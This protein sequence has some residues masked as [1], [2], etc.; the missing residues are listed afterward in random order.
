LTHGAKLTYALLLGYAWQ[1]GSCFP[2]QERL[3]EDL[4][5]E[6]KAVIRYLKELKDSGMVRVIRR[7][8]GQTNLYILPKLADVALLAKEPVS[9]PDV[10]QIGYQ[11]VPSLGQPVVLGS[12]HYVHPADKTQKR[13][14]SIR[15]DSCQAESMPVAKAPITL[16]A[17]QRMRLR[18]AIRGEEPCRDKPDS[19]PQDSQSPAGLTGHIAPGDSSPAGACDALVRPQAPNRSFRKSS[20][21]ATRR[22]VAPDVPP[23]EAEKAVAA[24]LEPLRRTFRDAASNRATITRAVHLLDCSGL[25]SAVF[26]RF[27]H[28]A[29]ARTRGSLQVGV[30]TSNPMAYFFACLVQLLDDTV[31]PD[32]PPEPGRPRRAG[33]PGGAPS[34]GAVA[35]SPDDHPLWARVREELAATIA[36]RSYREMVA[37]THVI[38]D[39][40][41]VLRVATGSAFQRDWLTNRLGKRITDILSDLGRENPRVE[42][43]V[44]QTVT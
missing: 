14:H 44:P 22:N 35:C 42:F 36:E 2:G 6:R 29:A 43:E 26:I 11:Q 32:A 1:E 17:S 20:S 3:S 39:D 9:S 5:V 18:S 37:P 25:E 21:R 27:L 16:L 33:P 38:A 13:S 10:P 24:I 12:G 4:G 34:H 7:G 8:L 15:L 41:L 19:P 31:H 28:E 30:I 23:H 40:G